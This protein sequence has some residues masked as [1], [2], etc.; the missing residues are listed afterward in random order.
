MDT[1]LLHYTARRF[2]LT[3]QPGYEL[4]GGHFNHVYEAVREGKDCILRLTPPGSEI[5]LQAMHA[6]TAWMGY[7]AWHGAPVARPLPSENG[8]LVEEMRSQGRVYLAS[9]FEKAEGILAQDVPPEW[10]QTA[11]LEKLGQV[12]GKL[13]AL[14]R[15][16]SPP[17][18]LRRPQ[19]DQVINLFNPSEQ[20]DDSHL[21]IR[22]RQAELLQAVKGL[23]KT[24]DGYGL[25]HAD[26]HFANFIVDPPSGAITLFDFD[27]CVYGWYVMDI[28]MPLLDA[29][30]VFPKDD[31][32]EFA[33]YFLNCFMRGYLEENDLDAGWLREPLRLFL[34]LLEINLYTTLYKLDATGM[35]DPWVRKFMAGRRE[36]IEAGLPYTALPESVGNHRGYYSSPLGDQSDEYN[37]I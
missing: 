1:N 32:D 30:V 28:A 19:W 26:L 18:E 8:N 36:R 31:P 12:V 7:L 22:Q 14:S 24:I 37:R 5:D 21:I 13:H 9:L 11:Q 16:Y 4:S 29:L 23:P 33:S 6:I 10:W 34:S 3:E 35:D 25:V 27:D 20:L 15:S 2:R 17:P